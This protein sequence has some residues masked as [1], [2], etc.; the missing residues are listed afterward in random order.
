M[1]DLAIDELQLYNAGDLH[2]TITLALGLN[3][4]VM[5]DKFMADLQLARLTSVHCSLKRLIFPTV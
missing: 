5:E 4:V 2:I 3:A 1:N